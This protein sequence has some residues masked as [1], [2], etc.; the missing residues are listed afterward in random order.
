MHSQKS[1]C[2]GIHFVFLGKCLGWLARCAPLYMAFTWVLWIRTQV[3][4]LTQ[5]ILYRCRHLYNPLGSFLTPKYNSVTWFLCFPHFAHAREHACACVHTHTHQFEL[6]FSH[7]EHGPQEEPWFTNCGLAEK[8]D[9]CS[10]ERGMK[11]PGRE[12]KSGMLEMEGTGDRNLS[13]FG[14]GCHLSDC[15]H[16]WKAYDRDKPG[17]AWEL[18]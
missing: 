4:V 15:L 12:K 18:G 11:I 14:H 1:L 9:S 3:L 16:I 17:L 7:S 6:Y 5:Q 2:R 13:V 8:G 10:W